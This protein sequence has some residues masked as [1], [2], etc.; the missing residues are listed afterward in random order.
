MYNDNAVSNS[1]VT[2]VDPVVFQRLFLVD[3]LLRRWRLPGGENICRNQVLW[4]S[5]SI[6]HASLSPQQDEAWRFKL[7]SHFVSLPRRGLKGSSPK[8]E[9]SVSIFSQLCWWKDE[10]SFFTQLEK[11]KIWSLTAKQGCS[12]LL[13][14]WGRWGLL[15][16][17]QQ[18]MVWWFY[19]S[20][21][22]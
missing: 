5:A 12:I 9:N 2:D 15:L 19:A 14:N 18:K 21:P 4:T 1:C 10:E 17:Q 8:N 16:K 20:I 13:N 6:W 22:A 7:G 3:L 11:K